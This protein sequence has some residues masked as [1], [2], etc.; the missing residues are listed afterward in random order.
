MKEIEQLELQEFCFPILYFLLL[1]Q[2]D[3]VIILI[4][5]AVF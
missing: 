2:I 3:V 5:N 4:T 1:E